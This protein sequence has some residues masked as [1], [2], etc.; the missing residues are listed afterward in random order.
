MFERFTDRARRA[1]VVLAEEEARIRN[2]DWIGT[3]HLLLSLIQD[4]DGVATKTLKSL[5]IS[6]KA[7][8]ASRSMTSSAR[9][10][11]ARVPGA[12]HLRRDPRRCWNWPRTRRVG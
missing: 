10:N 7:A 3:E 9:S 12:C 4:G 8:R 6:R 1:V 5:G 11:G 2:Q